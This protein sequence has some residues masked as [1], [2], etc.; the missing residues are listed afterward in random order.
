MIEVYV[1]NK[2]LQMVG[3]VDAY[4]SLIWVPRYQE[5]GDCEIYLEASAENIALFQMGFYLAR[6]DDDM[7]CK[8]DLI[9]IDTDAEEGNYLLVKGTDAK[10]ILDQRII[11]ETSTCNGP[12]EDFARRLVTD[13]LI[14]PADP[15]RQISLIELGEAAGFT[16]AVSEQVSYRNLGEKIREYCKTYGWGYRLT[17][18]ANSKLAFSLYKGSDRS[19]EVIFSDD[20]E[21]LSSST[22]VDSCQDMTNTALIG[23]EGQGADRIK[24]ELG[25]ATGIDRFEIFVDADSISTQVK[26]SELVAA[27][28]G[29]SITQ[30]QGESGR[31]FYTLSSLD[32]PIVD[33][34]HQE[35]LQERYSGTVVTIDGELFFRMSSPVY[36]A[37]IAEQGTAPTPED[38]DTVTLEELIYHS[39]LLNKGAEQTAGSGERESFTGSVITDVTFLYKQDYFLGDIVYV[40]NEYGIGADARIIEVIEAVDENGHT[41]E[42]TFEYI[43]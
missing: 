25:D 7:V 37:F 28:P 10:G 12:V 35:W 27:F 40:E 16:E 14:S 31:W 20:Y 2:S 6:L 36:I 1:F 19:N 38:N 33:A 23:G 26:Y 3:M 24:A 43:S 4:K 13:A 32:L 17:L 29:G 9:Q 15:D 5:T 30:K 42:P 11:W 41:V 21:N 18:T 34:E 8:I 22:Y 39:Y